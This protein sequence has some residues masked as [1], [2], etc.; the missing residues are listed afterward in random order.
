MQTISFMQRECNVHWVYEKA[1]LVF[2]SMPQVKVLEQIVS[3]T[4]QQSTA[5]CQSVQV[6]VRIELGLGPQIVETPSQGG[7]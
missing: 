4:C 5:V 1:V 6:L 7:L 3:H 2:G